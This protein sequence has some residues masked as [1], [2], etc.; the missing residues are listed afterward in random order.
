[1]VHLKD[2]SIKERETTG[3]FNYGRFYAANKEKKLEMMNNRG[4]TISFDDPAQVDFDDIRATIKR[5]TP[6]KEREEPAKE[7]EEPEKEKEEPEQENSTK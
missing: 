5:T 1:M 4:P 7:K 6:E 3:S 2:G